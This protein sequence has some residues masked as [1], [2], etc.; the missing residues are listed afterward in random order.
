MSVSD[1]GRASRPRR[2]REDDCPPMTQQDMRDA[3]GHDP[4]PQKL[5]RL[6]GCHDVSVRKAEDDDRPP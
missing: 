3:H 6:V 2:R 4:H 5:V 1:N